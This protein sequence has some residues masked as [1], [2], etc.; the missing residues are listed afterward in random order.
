MNLFNICFFILLF[1]F[2]GYFLGNFLLK[3]VI[4]K[5]PNSNIIK[6]YIYHVNNNEYYQ[7][8]IEMCICPPSSRNLYKNK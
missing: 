2:F 7:F 5:G 4:Y 3:K 1:F 8:E 6:K